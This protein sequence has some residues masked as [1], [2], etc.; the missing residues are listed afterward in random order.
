M[1]RF[2]SLLNKR[3]EAH[4]RAGDIQLSA[5]GTLVSDSGK[6]IFTEE[7]FSLN[8]KP[9]TIRVEVPYEFIIRVVA[10]AEN[11]QASPAQSGKLR[12]VGKKHS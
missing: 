11:S 8:G 10:L 4:Y 5:V 9:K 7:R 12:P 1:G 2:Q 6:S 3:V